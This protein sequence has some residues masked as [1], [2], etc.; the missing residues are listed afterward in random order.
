MQGEVPSEDLIFGSVILAVFLVCVFAAGLLLRRVKNARF[1]RAWRPLVPVIGGTVVADGGG[2]ASSSLTGR[3]RGRA[4]CATMAPQRNRYHDETAFR[5]NYFDLAL[6][7]TPGKADWHLKSRPR[8]PDSA[9]A[10]RLHD[11]GAMAILASIGPAE[12]AYN[13]RRRTLTLV[14]EPGPEWVPSPPR[15]EAQ[16]NVLL[17]LA[18]LNAAVNADPRPGGSGL[19]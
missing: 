14:Q 15:F 3:Y 19:A 7:E 16:L 18:E 2:S 4:V 10:Q 6:L 5:F 8:S 12:V 9:L 11:A 17:R 1:A 13:A